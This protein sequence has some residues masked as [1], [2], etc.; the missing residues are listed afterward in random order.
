MVIT[1]EVKIAFSLE[2][3]GAQLKDRVQ[4]AL[5]SPLF[6]DQRKNF[7]YVFIHH[8]HGDTIS[9]YRFPIKIFAPIKLKA[10]TNARA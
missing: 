6:P 4:N 5:P 1:T 2:Q 7:L 10:T 8:L 3:K 9:H